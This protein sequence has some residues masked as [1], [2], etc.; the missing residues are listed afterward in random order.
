MRTVEQKAWQEV[1]FYSHGA[2]Q[3]PIMRSYDIYEVAQYKVVIKMQTFSME[4]GSDN[5]DALEDKLDKL[6]RKIA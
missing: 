2:N 1:G 5:L 4:V 6:M 3:Y